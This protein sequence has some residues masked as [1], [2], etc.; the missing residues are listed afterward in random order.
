M[1]LDVKH[2]IAKNGKIHSLIDQKYLFEIYGRW[3]W[4][5]KDEYWQ[6]EI[7]DDKLWEVWNVNDISSVETKYLYSIRPTALF[8]NL[9]RIKLNVHPKFIDKYPIKNDDILIL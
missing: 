5:S 9:P 3:I 7:N 1:N 2:I 6:I 4:I 8:N